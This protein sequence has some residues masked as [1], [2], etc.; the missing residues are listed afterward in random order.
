MAIKTPEAMPVHK[1]TIVPR[2]RALGMVAQ[3][4]D[5]DELSVT[6]AQLL[7]RMDVALGGRFAEELVFGAEKVTTGASSDFEQATAIARAMVTQYGMSERLGPIVVHCNDGAE[8]GSQTRE[9]VDSEIKRLL[10][11]SCSR[12]RLILAENRHILDRLASALLQSETLTRTEIDAIVAGKTH[13]PV[14][15]L[16]ESNLRASVS[17]VASGIAVPY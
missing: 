3:L 2:G 17:S 12:V 9:I 13:T 16:P 1:A 5:S 10:D 7:A 15:S 6:K 4:P 14:V 8:W 11:E